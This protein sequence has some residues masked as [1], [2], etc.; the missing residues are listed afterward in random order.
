LGI[1]G[2]GKVSLSLGELTKPLKLRG[3]LADPSLAVDPAGTFVAIGKTVGG[4]ALFGPF[5]LA[6]ALAGGQFGDADPCDAAIEAVRKPPSE[7]PPEKPAT[8][9]P[10]RRPGALE[11]G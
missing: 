2:L 8:T 7:A 9:T 10:K 6:A 3:T 4:V 1:K 11:P 5:G